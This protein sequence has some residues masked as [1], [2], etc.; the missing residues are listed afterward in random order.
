MDWMS[1]LVVTVSDLP[2]SVRQNAAIC[3]PEASRGKY[4][5][6]CVSVPAIRIPWNNRVGYLI[7]SEINILPQW[8]NSLKPRWPKT[9]AIF[10]IPIMWQ[11]PKVILKRNKTP[12]ILTI[13]LGSGSSYI[14]AEPH[15]IHQ[16][17]TNTNFHNIIQVKFHWNTISSFSVF[18]HF[19]SC[20]FLHNHREVGSVHHLAP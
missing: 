17:S 16:C 18:E 14:G 20:T 6:F 1:N 8:F 12:W 13:G 2:G 7:L 5:A 9:S 11:T 4:L 19:S 3:S 15:H 10:S